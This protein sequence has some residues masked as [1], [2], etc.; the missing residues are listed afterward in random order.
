MPHDFTSRGGFFA[1]NAQAGVEQYRLNLDPNESFADSIDA[2]IE[3]ATSQQAA[4][5][6]SEPVHQASG[7]FSHGTIRLHWN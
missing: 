4:A 2:L 1:E 7:T 6:P 3:K 5:A